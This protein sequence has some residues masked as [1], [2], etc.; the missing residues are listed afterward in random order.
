MSMGGMCEGKLQRKNNRPRL[1]K[2]VDLEEVEFSVSC[3][4]ICLYLVISLSLSHTHTPPAGIPP[5]FLIQNVAL[6]SQF[7]SPAGL[8]KPRRISGLWAK[9]QRRVARTIK[10]SRNIGMIPHTSGVE[11]YQKIK[12]PKPE[13]PMLARGGEGAKVDKLDLLKCVPSATI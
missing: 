11:L 6:L 3:V 10:Q 12:P 5:F 1:C 4:G 9:C 7:L 2:K 13:D 8:I